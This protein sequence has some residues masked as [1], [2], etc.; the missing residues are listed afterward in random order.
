[1][2]SI[3]ENQKSKINSPGKSEYYSWGNNCEGWRILKSDSLSVIR[4]KMPGGATEV[5]H[6]HEQSQQVFY[7]LTG[8]AS[9]EIDGNI[10]SIN[11]NESLQ[12]SPG[13]LH[14]I[15]NS[16]DVDLEF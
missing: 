11:E 2:I 10:I 12:I 4:E 7:I 3:D 8:C 16:K 15:F 9:F 14:R 1:M 13:S 5:L 6:Y